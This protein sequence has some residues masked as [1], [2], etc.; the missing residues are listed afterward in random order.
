GMSVEER[1]AVLPELQPELATFNLGSMNYSMHPFLDVIDDWEYD[2][3]PEFLRTSKSDVFRNTFEDME[4]MLPTFEEYDT[5]PEFECYD[6]GHL[7]NLKYLER[8]GLLEP[9]YQLQFVMGTLGG[10]GTE[11]SNLTHMVHIADELFGD[12]YSFSVIGGGKAQFPLCSQSISMGG[13]V[14]VGMEDN[15][16]LRKGELASSNADMVE[17]VVDLADELA[18]R[19][20]ATPA[21]TREFLGLKGRDGVAF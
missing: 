10:I 9:P 17:K 3:E 5:K 6:V 4:E 16:Y 19:D 2:W 18:G 20:P 13:H 1:V 15:L 11:A 8:Q 7:Y 21:E 12:E 14:R